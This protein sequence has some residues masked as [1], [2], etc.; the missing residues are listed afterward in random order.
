M[1]QPTEAPA[2]DY[3]ATTLDGTQA[4]IY[5]CTL[6]DV[7][8]AHCPCHPACADHVGHCKGCA[9]RP[10]HDRSLL[11]GSCFYRKLRSPLRRVPALHDWLSSRKAGLRATAY[12]GDL[13]SSSKE[14]PLPF[15]AD[16]VDHLGVADRVLNAWA[17]K[18][19]GETDPGP[20]P[21]KWDDVGSAKWLDDHSGWAAEQRW[22][23]GLINDLAEL[24]RR[25]RAIAPWQRTGHSLPLPCTVCDQRTLVLFG[26]DDWVTCTNPECD[27]IIGWF[28]YQKL[29]RAIGRL[30]ESE[31]KAAG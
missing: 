15:N 17:A 24:E 10:S 25:A 12:D 6:T 5:G 11:C 16:I 20:G 7:H 27:K 14:A 31:G 30:Y 9:P 21:S 1:P 23:P 4:C 3:G 28:D 22:V 29:S 2:V 26:G 13:V 19:V 8:R 18:A